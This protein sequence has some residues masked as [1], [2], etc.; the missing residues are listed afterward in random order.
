LYGWTRREAE[1]RLNKMR[2]WI[3]DWLDKSMDLILKIIKQ[4]RI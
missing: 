1:Q 4:E 2:K 3:K